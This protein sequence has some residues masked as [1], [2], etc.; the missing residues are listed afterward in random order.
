M[1]ARGDIQA[2]VLLTCRSLLGVEDWRAKEIFAR[3][4][5]TYVGSR[6][7]LEES[8]QVECSFHCGGTLA[9]RGNADIWYGFPNQPIGATHRIDTVALHIH[10][11][12]VF[13][14][15]PGLAYYPYPYYRAEHKKR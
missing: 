1:L 9:L 15:G 13:A 3:R 8:S 5:M 11:R 14:E 10:G 12:R 2:L 6:K 7:A 4:L